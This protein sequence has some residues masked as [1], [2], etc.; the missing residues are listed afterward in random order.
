MPEM[1]ASLQP[2]MDTTPTP[3][4]TPTGAMAIDVPPLTVEQ[5]Q[6]LASESLLPP[7]SAPTRRLQLESDF[8]WQ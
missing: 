7:P 5:A 1:P 4:P 8:N 6:I 3:T 2:P